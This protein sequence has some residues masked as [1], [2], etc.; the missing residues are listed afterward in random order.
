MHT[1]HQDNAVLKAWLGEPSRRNIET[2][3]PSASGGRLIAD[4]LDK[5]VAVASQAIPS[6]RKKR[7]T[8]IAKT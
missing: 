4:V 5:Y 2:L 8:R 3:F 7:V 1:A 6:L